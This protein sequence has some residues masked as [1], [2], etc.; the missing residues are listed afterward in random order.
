MDGTVRTFSRR[1][2]ALTRTLAGHR[3]WANTIRLLGSL[4][5]SGSA[6]ATVKVWSLATAEGELVAT[7]EARNNMVLGLAVSPTLGLICSMGQD[8]KLFVWKPS[9]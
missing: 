2:N 7:L 9:E 1:A 5:V 8:G 3:H 4:L 6:D